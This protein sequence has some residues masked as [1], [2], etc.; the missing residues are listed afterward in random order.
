MEIHYFQRYHSKE[1]VTTANTM[2]LLSRLYSY[3]SNIFFRFLKSEIFTDAFDPEIKFNLQEKS[4]GS[5]SIPDA[6]IYQE[7]FKVVVETKLFDW[8]YSD[9]LVKH[10]S[11]FGDE[12][13]KVLITLAPQLMETEKLTDFENQLKEYNT[14]QKYPVM[15]INMTFEKLIDSIREFIDEKDYEM[16]EVL[17]DYMN[18]CYEDNLILV[19]DSWKRMK[20]Q[21]ARTTFDFNVKENLYYNNIDRPF[22]E[23]DYLGLYKEKSVRAVGKIV[24]IITAVVQDDEITF[25]VERGEIT[26]SKKAQILKAIEDGKKYG[27]MLTA[28]RYFFVDRFY[29]T[30]FKKTTPYAPMGSRVF[31]LTE[32]LHSDELSSTEEVAELLK[33]K[34]WN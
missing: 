17:D 15:H 23:H 9:Q 33:T 8:F 22:S 4:I 28:N 5:K 1:N 19:S 29:E 18:Y 31:D 11:S 16:Q 13:F 3:S 32:V 12:K 7:S 27:Y 2:L 34:T 26:D 24:A 6:T 10:L 25:N 14:K 30:D 20:V 21:L